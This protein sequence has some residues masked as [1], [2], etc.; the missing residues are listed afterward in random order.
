MA[1]ANG[2]SIFAATHTASDQHTAILADGFS[3]G[4]E[5]FL[6]GRIDKPAGVDND[7][8]RVLVVRCDLV[9]FYPELGQDAL[10]IDQGFWAAQRDKADLLATGNRCCA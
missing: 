3:N 7:Y 5:A 9:T 6:F 10:G 2:F 1:G 8:A 4:F